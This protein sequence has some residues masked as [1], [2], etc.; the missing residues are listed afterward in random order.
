MND[1]L[2]KKAMAIEEEVAASETHTEEE[3]HGSGI[4]ISLAAEKLFYVGGFQVTNAIL[5]SLLSLVVL[6]SLAAL[7]KRKVALVPSKIQ[8]VFE[9]ILEQLLEL[10][11]TVLGSR[12][13]SEK[14]LPLIATIFFFVVTS[15]WLGLLPGVGSLMFDSPEGRVPLLRSAAADLNFTLALGILAVVGVNLFGILAL[16]F[17][18]HAGKFFNFKG[19]IDFFVGILEF[20][21]E[22]AKMVSFSF[23]LFGNVFAGEVLLTIVAFLAPYFIPLP[24]LFLEVF[25]GFIQGLVFAMLALVF[26]GVAITGHDAE[27]EH[28]H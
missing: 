5:M 14:Y 2:V 25:V 8:S 17:R 9:M 20:V 6:G 1:L 12:D 11:D 28:A 27:H 16:G 24:F 4:H 21:S 26:V 15:N 19:P 18:A 13:K 23:R 22:F 10:M 7:L 3:A